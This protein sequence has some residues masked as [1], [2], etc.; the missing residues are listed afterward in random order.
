MWRRQNVSVKYIFKGIVHQKW[1][2]CHYLL[3]LIINSTT[4]F[5]SMENKNTEEELSHRGLT[6]HEGLVNDDNLDFWVNY[7]LRHPLTGPGGGVL[8]RVG[9]SRVGRGFD[10]KKDWG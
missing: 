4:E 7:P 3:T 9:L 2:F 10:Q 5:H 8:V 6:K 1:K